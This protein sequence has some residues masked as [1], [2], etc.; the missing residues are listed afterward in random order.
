MIG[1]ASGMEMYYP[2]AAALGVLLLGIERI[3]LASA[4]GV[5]AALLIITL[6]AVV[7]R[8]TGLQPALTMFSNFIGTAFAS[9]GVLLVIVFYALRE[10]P[11]PNRPRSGNGSFRT[12][13]SR[14]FCPQLSPAG[15]GAGRRV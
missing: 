3:V 7:P 15:S 5:V 4:I 9:S 8:T 13:C 10:L 11:G 1:T 14:I 6:E 2:I 12:R